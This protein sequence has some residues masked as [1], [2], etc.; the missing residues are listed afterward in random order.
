MTFVDR[1][2]WESYAAALQRMWRE[3]PNTT[4]QTRAN[5][6][7][8]GGRGFDKGAWIDW[9]KSEAEKDNGIEWCRTLVQYA[10]EER[11]K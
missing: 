4:T 8:G 6:W 10:V 11:I 9:V 5:R 7:I 1:Y 2:E 3:N